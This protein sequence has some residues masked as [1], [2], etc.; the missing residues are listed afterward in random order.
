MKIINSKKISL[1]ALFSVVMTL[2]LSLIL[3]GAT[4]IKKTE[5]T[6]SYISKTLNFFIFSI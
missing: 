2:S 5:M 1:F 4:D 3:V 6:L